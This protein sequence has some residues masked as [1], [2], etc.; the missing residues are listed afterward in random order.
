MRVATRGPSSDDSLLAAKLSVPP[1]RT[2]VPRPRLIARLNEGIRRKL[3]LVKAGAGFGKTTLLSEW[4]S[5]ST[6]PVAWVSL[7]E[8]DNVPARFWRYFVAAL[9]TVHPG[10]SDRVVTALGAEPIPERDTALTA[11]VNECAASSGQY[12][13]ILDDY[14]VIEAPDIHQGIAFMLDHAPLCAHIVIASRSQ[15]PLP[16]ARLRGRRE[17]AEVHNDDLRFTRDEAIRFFKDVMSLDLSPEQVQALMERSEGWA[18]GLQLAALSLQG[19]EDVADSIASFDGE[20]AYIADYLTEEVL[21]AQPEKIQRFML[22]TSVLR[23][24]S[25]PLCEAVTGMQ[26]SQTTLQRLADSNLFVKPLDDRRQWYRYDRLFAGLLRSQLKRTCAG[27]ET[28]L[29]KRASAWCQ[30]EGW[31][32]DA[33]EYALAGQDHLSAIGLMEKEGRALLGDGYAAV[34]MRWLDT[35]PSDLVRTNPRLCLNYAWAVVLSGYRFNLAEE[36]LMYVDHWLAQPSAVGDLPSTAENRELRGRL[37]AARAYILRLRGDLLGAIAQA[38]QALALLQDGQLE[39]RT[40]RYVLAQA[41]RYGGDTHSWS[42]VTTEMRL[43]DSRSTGIGSDLV[44]IDN[45]AE[46]QVAVGRLSQALSTWEW[47]LTL[48][49][50]RDALQL[51]STGNLCCGIGAVLYQRNRLAEALEQVSKGIELAQQGSLMDPLLDG[52]LTRAF[53]E[54]A[55]GEPDKALN[56]L[57]IAEQLTYR[58][59]DTVK[60]SRIGAFRARIWLTQGRRDAAAEWAK[61]SGPW[62]AEEPHYAREFEFLTQARILIATGRHRDALKLLEKAQ[63]SAH[64][65]GRTGSLVEIHALEALAFHAHNDL[66]K[67]LQALEHALSLAAAEGY[68]R[69]FVDEGPQMAELLN[70]A[71]SRGLASEFVDKLLLAFQ[72]ASWTEQ[73]AIPAPTE[74]LSEREMEVMRLLAAH[75]T[76]TEIAQELIISP[77]TA[78]THIKNIYKKLD[79][80]ERDEAVEHARVLGLLSR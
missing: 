32:S 14:H 62:P 72:D 69:V 5:Q 39:Q 57:Q 59:R 8:S 6:I 66:P 11:L 79:A 73:A 21:R 16:L 22:Q 12:I 23:R 60:M 48:A 58:P 10:I 80:H 20:H 55:K 50:E 1:L 31:L 9:Q 61:A 43:L 65:G 15:P 47:G 49:A 46:L 42:Q 37:C 40:A 36:Y 34:M 54:R 19:R 13:L 64:E 24:M 76:S 52:Y 38:N 33:I 45:L 28:E 29:L 44:V 74:P 35:V 75:L 41:Y 70:H 26:D 71:A 68:V 4:A 27:E 2:I 63:V 18:T 17:M 53:I 77:H 67:A 3:I 56:T 30:R 7:E 25:G 78:R 51:P